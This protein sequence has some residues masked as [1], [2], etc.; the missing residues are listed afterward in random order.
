MERSNREFQDWRRA[1]EK[2]ILQL[3]KTGRANAAA[4]QKMEALQEKQR[5]VL[6]RKTEE[7]D[8]ARKR[9]KVWI[10]LDTVLMN[11]TAC[12]C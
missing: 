11:R 6:R 12:R 10:D 2:E 5:A 4:L 1:R 3:R 7:A 8:A 9:L